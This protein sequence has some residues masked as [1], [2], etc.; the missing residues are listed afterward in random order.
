MRG[1]VKTTLTERTY[2]ALKERILDQRLAAGARLNIDALSREL[3]VSSSPIREALVRLET[4]RLVISELYAGYSV[5]PQPTTEYLHDLL[6]FR[7]QIE[8]YCARI[9]A[10]AKRKSTINE[11]RRALE[12]MGQSPKIGTKYKEYQK[13]VHAD[14]KFHEIIVNSANNQVCS[15]IYASLNPIML[16]SRLYH[17]TESNEARLKAVLD[18]HR[19]ILAAFENGDGAEAEAAVRAHLEGG[20]KRLLDGG[21]KKTAAPALRKVSAGS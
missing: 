2:E 17:D 18:E 7:I 1:L 13:L 21:T 19:R 10:Q 6:D 12:K 5:A 3:N 8:G 4:E 14:G 15:D 9:G 11:L 20:R 16:Q